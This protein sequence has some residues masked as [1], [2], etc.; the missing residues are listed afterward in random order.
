MIFIFHCLLNKQIKDA[1]GKRRKRW[2]STRHDKRT[3]LNLRNKCEAAVI[4]GQA[5]ENLSNPIQDGVDQLPEIRGIHSDT[6]KISTFISQ[7]DVGSGVV[8]DLP[9]EGS[10]NL[11]LSADD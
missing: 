9:L 2:V 5:A 4:P 7:D 11:T 6:M 1:F 8:E 10:I 3:S